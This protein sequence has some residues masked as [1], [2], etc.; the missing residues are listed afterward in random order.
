MANCA[1]NIG[2]V[3]SMG[4]TMCSERFRE[5]RATAAVAGEA[6]SCSKC[7]NCS[8]LRISK[9]SGPQDSRSHFSDVIIAPPISVGSASGRSTLNFK[10]SEKSHGPKMD[11]IE[12]AKR[13]R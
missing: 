8:L 7:E 10:F 3:E 1:C 11:P 2:R 6:A 4:E 13:N 12:V 9:A 5:N